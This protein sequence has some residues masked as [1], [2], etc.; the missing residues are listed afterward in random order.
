[1]VR[2]DLLYS[3]TE[4]NTGRYQPEIEIGIEMFSSQQ[5]VPSNVIQKKVCFSRTTPIL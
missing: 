5:Y 4:Y 1:M 3:S 2:F